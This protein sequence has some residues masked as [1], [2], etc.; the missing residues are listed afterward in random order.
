ME[1]RRE[2]RGALQLYNNS[3]KAR[4]GEGRG[5][6]PSVAWV[7]IQVRAECIN[8]CA[9]YEKRNL[10]CRRNDDSSIEA[11]DGGNKHLRRRRIACS[12]V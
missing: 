2:L 11:G 7:V 12:L 8:S 3:A 6:S 9:K 1:S 10:L 5:I 4:Y